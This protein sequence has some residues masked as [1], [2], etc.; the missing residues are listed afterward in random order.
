AGCA[1]RSSGASDA[2]PA[3]ANPA[4]PRFVS[5]VDNPWFPLKPGTVYRYRGIKDGQ[6]SNEVFTVVH[7]TRVIQGVRCTA[8]RDLL[9]TRGRLHERTTD[10]HAQDASGNVRDYGEAPTQPDAR[11]QVA[12]RAASRRAGV[13][14][15]RA[16]S[17]MPAAP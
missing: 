9:Y 10:W 17:R 11:R 3:T 16:R 2:V 14:A 5:Q 4:P 12:S 15:A 13:N 7:G 1:S 6:P 8:V